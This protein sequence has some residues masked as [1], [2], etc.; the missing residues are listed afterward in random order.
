[1]PGRKEV[2]P[3]KLQ[4]VE[5]MSKL[6][7]ESQVVGVLNLHKLPANVFQKLKRELKDKADIKVIKKCI[8]TRALEKADKKEL[9]K[10][11]GLYPALILT[12]MNPFKLYKF[13]QNNKSKAFAKPGDLAPQDITVQAGPTDLPPGPAISTLSGA[14]IPA[15]VEG[16]KIAIIRDKVV[17]EAGKEISIELASVLQMLK[18]E[19]MEIGLDL[20]S[21]WEDGTVYGKDVLAIDE[22][23]VLSDLILAST[24]AFN[25][26]FNSGFPTSETTG[27]M[28]TKAFMNAKALGLE[29]NILDRGIIED[30]LAKAKRHADALKAQTG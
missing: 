23:K 1:M 18:V 12:S 4:A 25:L 30:I 10:D 26:A 24:N 21:I 20:L 28:I 9:L 6:I 15:K 29:A 13:L 16:G 5:D 3:E 17:C 8:L 2:K 19:P 14:G 11:V 27:F 22:A 7:S